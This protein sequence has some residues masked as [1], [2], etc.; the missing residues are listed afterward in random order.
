MEIILKWIDNFKRVCD[1]LFGE[2]T[3]CSGYLTALSSGWTGG[4][5]S[6]SSSRSCP[7][8]R[9][10]SRFSCAG[11]PPLP[12]KGESSASLGVAATTLCPCNS[13]GGEL[14]LFRVLRIMKMVTRIT[15]LQLVVS[16][17]MKAFR[18]MGHIMLLLVRA[19]CDVCTC[20]CCALCD[21]NCTRVDRD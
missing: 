3:G 8:F 16:T 2:R 20:T 13:L 18:S 21:R 11:L 1:V 5:C 7:L 15:S 10:S 4:T 19:Q 14:R 9:A 6:T 12:S 17:I